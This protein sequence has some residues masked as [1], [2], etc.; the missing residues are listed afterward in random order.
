MHW[1]TR[2]K[3]VEAWQKEVGIQF[4]LNRKAFGRLP[5]KFAR[6]TV[7]LWSI[8][9]IDKDNRYNA[10]KPLID[11]FKVSLGNTRIGTKVYPKPG[12][13]I[14]IDDKEKYVDWTVNWMKAKNRLNEYVE[15]IFELP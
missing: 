13:G 6:I 14:I 10:C 2:H 3:W 15:I 8:Q 12:L 11:A 7:N 5:L 9:E 4:Q 1:A